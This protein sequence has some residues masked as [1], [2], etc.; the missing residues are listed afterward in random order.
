MLSVVTRPIVLSVV[1]LGVVMLS[2]VML[3][4]VMLSVVMLSV[5]APIPELRTRYAFTSI[6]FLKMRLH[7]RRLIA[8]C[9]HGHVPNAHGR[10]W[11]YPL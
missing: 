4:V 3:S 5:V 9:T 7:Q 8:N 11:K 1:M 6:Y 10:H 2:V